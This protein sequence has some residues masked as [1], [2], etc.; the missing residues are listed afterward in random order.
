MTT[1]S[2]HKFKNA[3]DTAGIRKFQVDSDTDYHLFHDPDNAKITCFDEE[4]ETFYNF[5]QKT[6]NSS[7]GWNDPVVVTAVEVGDIHVVK[8]GATPSKIREFIDAMGFNFTDEEK[9][10]IVN[11]N[12]GNYEIK[13]ITGDYILAGF[14]EL[15]DEEIAKLTPQEKI[16]YENKLEIFEERQKMGPNQAAQITY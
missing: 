4:T 1:D 8:F 15:S 5:R 14:K 6:A 2:W 13:P 12:K 7:E 16:D 11:I 10:A 3:I 9:K